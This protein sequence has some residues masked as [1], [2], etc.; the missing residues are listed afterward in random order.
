MNKVLE[1]GKNSSK[2]DSINKN[3]I[4]KQ[5]FD[6]KIKLNY[7][8]FGRMLL[9]RLQ[10]TFGVGFPEAEHSIRTE[11]PFFTCK[12]PLVLM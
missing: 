2:L 8:P 12:C 10:V 4:T 3:S 9:R 1:K 11:E 7:V 5:C 6:G